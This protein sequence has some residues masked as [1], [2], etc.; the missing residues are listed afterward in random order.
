MFEKSKKKEFLHVIEGL[1]KYTFYVIT[2][3]FS[4]PNKT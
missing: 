3:V 2:V 4:E 1:S